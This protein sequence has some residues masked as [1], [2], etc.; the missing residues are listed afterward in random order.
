MTG[1]AHGPGA[2]GSAR[3][4][5]ALPAASTSASVGGLGISRLFGKLRRAAPVPKGIL[6][7][8]HGMALKNSIEPSLELIALRDGIA[9]ELSQGEVEPQAGGHELLSRNEC[10]S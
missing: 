4:L 7:A 5:T 9:H 1:A 6:K 8:S 2:F 10:K 3:G